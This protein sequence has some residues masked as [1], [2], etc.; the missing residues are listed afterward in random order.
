MTFR[1]KVQLVS[2]PVVKTHTDMFSSKDKTSDENERGG[3]YEIISYNPSP[4]E[5][6]E[7]CVKLRA[8]CNDLKIL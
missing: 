3:G 7:R 8:K 4:E 2:D 5:K 1:N 6:L